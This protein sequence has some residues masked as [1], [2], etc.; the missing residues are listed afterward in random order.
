M[1][2]RIVIGQMPDG[3]FGVRVSQAGYDVL[4]N[5]VDNEKL[6]FNSDWGST[7][8]LYL[9]GSYNKTSSETTLDTISFTSL[10]YVP[11]VL[12]SLFD[13]SVD[14][15]YSNMSETYNSG[16]S[17]TYKRFWVTNTA[18]TI[19]IQGPPAVYNYVIT[20]YRYA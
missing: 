15:W 16:T 19:V 14:N 11:V 2:N 3:S 10:G 4:S 6:I 18:S 7:V 12:V 1:A 8:P 17:S 20:R 9:K 13:G 5:P